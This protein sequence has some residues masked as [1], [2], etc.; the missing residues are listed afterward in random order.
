[1]SANL[2]P[3]IA[4]TPNLDLH[5]QALAHF[6][7]G[8][9][10][11]AVELWQQAI[12][13]V[14]T[15]VICYWYLGLTLLLQAQESEAQL[16][17]MTPLLE[18]EPDQVEQWSAEL[19]GILEAE[20][21]RQQARG[22]DEAAW[23]IRRH[24]R[25][26]QPERLDNLLH[27]L[28]LE[29]KLYQFSIDGETLAQ[30]TQAL[31]QIAPRTL[32]S[33]DLLL[34]VVQQILEFEPGHA[35]VLTF[36]EASIPQFPEPQPLVQVLVEKAKA[37]FLV[38]QNRAAAELGKICLR[39]TPDDLE[40]IGVVIPHLQSVDGDEI[41]LSIR[42]AEQYLA[43]ALALSDKILACQHLLTGLMSTGGQWHR[44]LAVYETYKSLM[45]VLIQP[46][47]GQAAELGPIVR[48]LTAGTFFFYMEDNPRSNRP[49]RN[50]VATI[51]Q[52]A[53]RSYSGKAPYQF[54]QRSTQTLKIGYLSESLRRHSVGWLIRW[55]LKHHDRDRF[56]VHLYSCRYTGDPLQQLL[57]YEYGDRFHNM[58]LPVSLVADQIYQDEIDVLVELDSFTSFTG[59]AVATLKPAPVQV[60]WLGYDAAGLP[61]VDY[62]IADPYVLPESAQE[63]YSEKIW[64][65]P[66][67]YIAVDGFEISAPSLRRDQLDIPSE[68]IVYLSSQTGLKRNPDNV[69]QQMQILRA[70]PNSYFLIKSIKS[71]PQTLQAFFFEI[72]EAEG[73]SVDRLRFLPRVD[74]EAVHRG[75]M[76]IAD[77]VLDTFPYTG[78]TTTLEALWVGL[79]IVTRVGEQFAARNSYT[80]LMNVGVTEGIA[81]NDE[82][83][84]EWG[85][86][87]GQD[88]ALRQKIS[89]RLRQSR[90]T[91]PLWNAKQF[92]REMEHA[93]EQMWARYCDRQSSHR[94]ILAPINPC[95][96]K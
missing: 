85:I 36:I 74:S 34:Q 24:W 66:Q 83:Y 26:L 77:V 31:A 45:A 39:L 53:S 5:T 65:L 10:A 48:V 50:Q 80:M 13:A 51:A 22:A 58:T 90:H 28:L 94:S 91:S 52:A 82:E 42:L 1:M 46:Q 95:T 11:V 23:L 64:R 2:P 19:A 76:A 29:L 25:E 35:N 56:E 68:A 32:A 71:D 78:A 40:L 70:V 89:W 3:S 44:A 88:E 67:T 62:F 73:V 60:N 41:W 38:S 49:L 21:D 72:A 69:R 9:Y 54:P 30:A 96:D 47:K 93:Y 20:A 86:R 14:P 16:T 4:S 87:L 33:T 7:S 15:Q 6:T 8:E 81:W 55:L 84:I 18:A 75:N 12:A 57:E 43:Q 37:L 79:P 92:A 27:L 59:C 61:A 17:W 63:Y